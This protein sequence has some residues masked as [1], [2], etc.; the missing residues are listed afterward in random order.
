MSLSQTSAP[1]HVQPLFSSLQQ[2]Q[3]ALQLLCRASIGR[4]PSVTA[5]KCVAWMVE[6]GSSAFTTV[7]AADAAASLYA[8]AVAEAAAFTQK[9]SFSR[10][11]SLFRHLSLAPPLLSRS[12]SLSLSL[13]PLSLTHTL[14]LSFSP[15][16]FLSLSL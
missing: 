5:G 14:F 10:S 7:Q 13:S 15:T 16:I 4:C 8:V 2:L 9:V 6:P 11:I 1:T 12:L 3:L